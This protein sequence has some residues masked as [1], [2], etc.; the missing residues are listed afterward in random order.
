VELVRLDLLVL[1]VLLV[2][3]DLLVELDLQGRL[4]ELVRLDLLGVLALQTFQKQQAQH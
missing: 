1:K 2:Q 4:V 3:Q